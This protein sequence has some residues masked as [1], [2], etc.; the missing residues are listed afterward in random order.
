M[1]TELDNQC[2]A[3]FRTP[4][5]LKTPEGCKRVRD[6]QNEWDSAT[7]LLAN[8][9]KGLL[10]SS[11]FLSYGGKYDHDGMHQ[12]NAMIGARDRKQEAFLRAVA[13]K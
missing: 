3:L 2:T 13:G 9:L 8:T 7:H 5:S 12:I 11:V 6:A 4:E 10:D 1:M